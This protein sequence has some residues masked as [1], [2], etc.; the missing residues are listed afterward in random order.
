MDF[1]IREMQ[2]QDI[3]HV[4]RIAKVSWKDTYRN[5]IPADIQRLFLRAVYNNKNISQQME[6]S[7]ISIA[8]AEQK[9][10]GF[11]VYAPVSQ[12]GVTDIQALYMHPKFQSKGIGTAFLQHI[13]VKSRA[14]EIHLNVEKRNE[15]AMHFYLRKGFQKRTEFDDSLLGHPLQMVKLVCVID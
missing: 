8:E 4:R 3:R 10:V 2:K 5:I 13:I 6:D 14:R 1:L 11:V 12:L 15:K 9:A 7:Y